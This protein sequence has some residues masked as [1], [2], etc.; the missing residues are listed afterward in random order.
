M[1]HPACSA[2]TFLKA[3]ADRELRC[4]GSGWKTFGKAH[5]EGEVVTQEVRQDLAES[6]RSGLGSAGVGKQPLVWTQLSD[7][8]HSAGTKQLEIQFGDLAYTLKGLVPKLS[9]GYLLDHLEDRVGYVDGWVKALAENPLAI[10]IPASNA[11]AARYE[12]GANGSAVSL[13]QADNRRQARQGRSGGIAGRP[14]A[15]FEA[16]RCT[17]SDSADQPARCPRQP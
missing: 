10:L 9:A 1:T 7:T 11:Q 14:R 4:F 15:L 12:C 16:G 5:F 3:R 17:L 6:R 13:T 8:T 2:T